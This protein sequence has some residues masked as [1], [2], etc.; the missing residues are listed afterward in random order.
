[1]LRA[2]RVEC[3]VPDENLD[4]ACVA[5]MTAQSDVRHRDILF[6][7]G[8]T[9]YLVANVTELKQGN[10]TGYAGFKTGSSA[11]SVAQDPETG[12]L[13]SVES[14]GESSLEAALRDLEER[15][16]SVEASAEPFD[17]VNKESRHRARRRERQSSR[18]EGP[19]PPGVESVSAGR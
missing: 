19:M 4:M 3:F 16:T 5:E 2:D 10:W 9:L 6:E 7:G 18:L 14:W 17:R 15:F 13:Y 11:S 12:R 1:M 8:E